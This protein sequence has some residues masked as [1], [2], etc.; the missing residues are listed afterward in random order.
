MKLNHSIYIYS[1]GLCGLKLSLFDIAKGCP[2]HLNRKEMEEVVHIVNDFLIKNNP[3]MKQMKCVLCGEKIVGACHNP[4]PLANEG[5]CCS[6]C[7]SKVLVARIKET[8]RLMIE[9]E[10]ESM[11]GGAK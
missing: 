3:K 10:K 1:G 2:R 9:A 8:G 6:A 4:A 11:K 5:K 7:N